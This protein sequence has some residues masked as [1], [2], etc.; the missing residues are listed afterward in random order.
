MDGY[1]LW[2]LSTVSNADED[3]KVSGEG[4]GI[5]KRRHLR[6]RC[7]LTDQKAMLA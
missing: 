3:E 4:R 7:I 1:Q 2:V 5:N 6:S